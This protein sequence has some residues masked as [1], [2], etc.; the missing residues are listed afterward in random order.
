MDG[1]LAVV[2]D[3][4]VLKGQGLD[5]AGAFISP[6]LGMATTL[7]LGL[8]VRGIGNPMARF[9]AFVPF[10]FAVS[11]IL[12]HGT[13]LGRPDHQSL[14]IFSLAVALGAECRLAGEPT[15][16]WAR[17]SGTAWAFALWVS[18]YEPAILLLVVLATW[19][20][21][22]PRRLLGRERRC[23]LS[24]F[25]IVSAIAFIIEGWRVQFPDPLFRG[26]LEN[27]SRSIGELAH[28]GFNL[29]LGWLGLGFLTMP[30]LLI[31]AGYRIDRRAFPILGLMGVLIALT[32]WQMRWGYFLALVFVMALPW[33]LALLQRRWVAS[34]CFGLSL[35]TVAAE[36]DRQLFPSPEIEQ[37][38]IQHRREMVLLREV[39]GQ[40]RSDEVQ[41]FLAPWWN[42]PALCY[43]SRQPG[44]AGSSHQSIGGIVDSAQ[45]YLAPTPEAAEPVLRTR[46]VRWLIAD[47]P[48]RAVENSQSILNQ[49]APERPLAL[50][51][52]E[53]PH[54][55][56]P[57]FG[58]FFSN[59]FFKLYAIDQAKLSP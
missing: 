49:T 45:V 6:L 38:R 22:A 27:W 19:L 30:V 24:A 7:F 15:Q 48:G 41:P 20:I 29:F 36:W 57:A 51:L 35:W 52:M 43:W 13:V 31:L 23:W 16:A 10:V 28:P 37:Q 12:V 59:D 56:G 32:F 40:M 47:D 44:V 39:A 53:Q 26:F 25:V 50:L 33:Q 58:P 34:V 8:W 3:A 2:D 1:A 42:T 5:L 11:P 18:L 14:L 4:S 21:S 54:S 17:T 46:K 9:G 55:V